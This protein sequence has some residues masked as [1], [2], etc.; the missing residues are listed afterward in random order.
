M[1]LYIGSS[2]VDVPVH[3][4]W[5]VFLNTPKSAHVPPEH[6]APPNDE[7]R[8]ARYCKCLLFR[9]PPPTPT[10]DAGF[11]FNNEQRTKENCDEGRDEGQKTPLKKKG[12]LPAL[13][14][15]PATRR[16][17]QM[18]RTEHKRRHINSHT[19]GTRHHA[20]QPQ[21]PTHAP[22]QQRRRKHQTTPPA[23]IWPFLT[24]TRTK[25]DTTKARGR[26]N[27]VS[28]MSSGCHDNANG[29]THPNTRTTSPS[30]VDEQHEMPVSV[31]NAVAA[32]RA[33]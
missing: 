25:C 13:P 6:R 30:H 5:V 22:R 28:W 29:R 17:R 26:A 10:A 3:R 33:G 27:G 24:S 32:T 8:C 20:P 4:K 2:S 1:C 15:L 31:E 7:I 12:A 11:L 9:S 21:Q 19:S 23:F 18:P 16:R 14:A